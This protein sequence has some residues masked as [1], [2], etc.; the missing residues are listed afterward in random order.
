MTAGWTLLT[1]VTTAVVAAIGG[2][3]GGLGLPMGHIPREK[4]IV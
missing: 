4:R 2:S 1:L 3:L